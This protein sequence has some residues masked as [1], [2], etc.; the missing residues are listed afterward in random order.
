MRRLNFR[1]IRPGNRP[2]AACGMAVLTFGMA[3]VF[4]GTDLGGQPAK[5]W[6]NAPVD[7]LPASV[8]FTAAAF[9]NHVCDPAFGGGPLSGQ[10]VWVFKLPGDH[11][12]TG[13]FVSVTAT[14]TTPEGTE[15]TAVVP[16]EGGGVVLRAKTSKAWVALPEGWTLTGAKAEITGSAPLFVLA[17][18]CPAEGTVT[19]PV[20]PEPDPSDTAEPDPSASAGPHPSHSADPDPSDDP[21]PD[22]SAS[23]VLLPSG[24]PEPSVAPSGAPEP[25]VA[26]SVLPE[27]SVAPSLAPQPSAPPSGRAKPAHVSSALKVSPSADPSA[28]PVE[29]PIVDPS[30]PPSDPIVDPSAPP[31]DPIV[32]PSAP[33][34]DPIV[35]PSTPPSDPIVD[36]SAPPSE[37]IVDPSAPPSDPIVDPSAAPEPSAPPVAPGHRPRPAEPGPYVATALIGLWD[38]L[39]AWFR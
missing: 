12:K 38:D 26:P 29:P 23:A 30:A 13:D 25:S 9:E 36:P 18:T 14:F 1:F 5:A 16:A 22:P 32:D 6:A 33:P 34:V 8:G 7:I 21:N 3:L 28:A 4:A 17:R 27:P 35:D 2:L 24:A 37:P 39:V 15:A 31:S 20:A 10:D 11:A 19:P